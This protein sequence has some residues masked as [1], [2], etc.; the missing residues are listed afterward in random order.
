MKTLNLQQLQEEKSGPIW[1]INNSFTLHPPGGDIYV[2]VVGP[3]NRPIP[4]A[5]ELTWLPKDLTTLA[6]R[7]SILESSYFYR[8]ITEGILLAITQED[9]MALLSKKGADREQDRLKAAAEAVKQASRAKGIS[10]TVTISGGSETGQ[11]Q[12]IDLTDVDENQREEN[13]TANFR[14]WVRSLNELD[15]EEAISRIKVRGNLT[16]EECYYLKRNTEH[17]RIADVIG[18]KLTKL[19][20]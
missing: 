17:E 8:A 7:K 15:V 13:I 9:A 2:T 5:I 11:T 6:P 1:V 20:G 10:D 16:L 14:A 4:L 3:D 12:M 18:K 19:S